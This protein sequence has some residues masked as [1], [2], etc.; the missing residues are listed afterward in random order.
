MDVS[1]CPECKS[2]LKRH[3]HHCT[4]YDCTLNTCEVE[5]VDVRNGRV[6]VKRE[7]A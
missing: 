7:T 4:W 3:C 2:P 6:Q 1:L 5:R